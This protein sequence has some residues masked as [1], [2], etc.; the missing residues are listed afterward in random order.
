MSI[1][2]DRI[3]PTLVN[4]LIDIK[5]DNSG[6][7]FVEHYEHKAA[8]EMVFASFEGGVIP[9]LYNVNFVSSSDALTGAISIQI[10]RALP[11]ATNSPIRWLLLSGATKSQMKKLRNGPRFGQGWECH[12]LFVI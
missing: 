5:R 1:F 12:G 7:Y 10:T 2:E 9:H 6:G 11:R 8:F 3:Q 4:I